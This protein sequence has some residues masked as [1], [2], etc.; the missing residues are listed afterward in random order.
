MTN[1]IPEAYSMDPAVINGAI[2][3]AVT[4][5]REKGIHGKGIT[6]FLLAR[7]AELTG[8]DSLASNI[9]LVY[10]NARVAAQTAAAYCRL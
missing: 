9:Q 5:C 3:Q 2:D 8:G 4:E 1:P 10:N 6:P 7:V